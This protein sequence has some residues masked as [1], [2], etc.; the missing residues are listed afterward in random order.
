MSIK[1]ED[2]DEQN[3][4]SRLKEIIKQ[5]IKSQSIAQPANKS[6]EEVAQHDKNK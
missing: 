1:L 2:N 5:R 3:Q 6:I 4:R